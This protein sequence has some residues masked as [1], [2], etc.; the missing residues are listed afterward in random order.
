MK[1]S[2][3]VSVFC[4]FSCV[5]VF[6]FFV[7]ISI[8]SVGHF[9]LTA[10]FNQTEKS[11]LLERYK[12]TAKINDLHVFNIDTILYFVRKGQACYSISP[13][14]LT[15]STLLCCSLFLHAS[16]CS[17]SITE[18]PEPHICKKISSRQQGARTATVSLQP[19]AGKTV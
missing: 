14:C 3:S 16:L 17:K 18:A 10:L 19:G 13:Y 4:L 15:S 2:V 11:A 1:F 5:C 12:N 7:F 9:I 6:V 8:L